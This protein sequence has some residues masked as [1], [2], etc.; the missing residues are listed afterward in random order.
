[1]EKP[2]P[3]EI[4]LENHGYDVTWI[5]PE[6]GERTKP[7][8]YR[9]ERFTGEPPDKSHP[10]LLYIYRDGEIQSRKSYYFDSREV[11]IQ[12]QQAEVNPEKTPYKVAAPPD[13]EMAAA[14]GPKFSLRIAA[15]PRNARLAG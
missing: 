15:G 5:N 9:G 3:V 6:T 8:G 7:K 10:W 11:P 2:G 1:M 4:T 14:P 12:I 13:G